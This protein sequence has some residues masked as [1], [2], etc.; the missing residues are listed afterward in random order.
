MSVP[1]A[2]FRERIP[3]LPGRRLARV[4]EG[5]DF[6]VYVVDGEW[7]RAVTDWNDARIGDPALDL[8]WLLKGLGEVFGNELLAAY[9]GV[10]ARLH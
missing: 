9:A 2:A 4:E 8:A 7:I 3:A 6:D 10:R 5:W 1:L